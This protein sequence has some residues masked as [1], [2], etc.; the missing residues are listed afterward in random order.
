MLEALRED[1]QPLEVD[2]PYLEST[3]TGAEPWVPPAKLGQLF[4]RG[5]ETSPE[6]VDAVI[7]ELDRS[8]PVM[9]LLKLSRSF[10]LPGADGVVHPAA[11][12]IPDPNR[13]HAVLA[14]GHGTANG[15]RSLLVRNS[16]GRK[17]GQDGHAWLTEPFLTPRIFAAAKLTEDVDVPA[18][19]TTA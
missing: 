12:E 13:R 17:W 6:M 11:G 4:R 18:G 9:L 19:S 15:H 1:G 14:V 5:G 3:P 2:W 7:E 10:F 8:V 16:W